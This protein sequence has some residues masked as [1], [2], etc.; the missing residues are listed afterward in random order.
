MARRLCVNLVSGR[1]APGRASEALVV[2]IAAAASELQTVL[3]LGAEG[4]RFAL[5]GY[6]APVR[7]PGFSPLPELLDAFLRAG[8]RLWVCA[9]A[10]HGLGLDKAALLSGAELVGGGRLVEFLVGEGTV[11]LSY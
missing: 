7:D 9:P 8:G 6:A 2:A 4:V 11:T 5:Q 3:F 1:E 10:F